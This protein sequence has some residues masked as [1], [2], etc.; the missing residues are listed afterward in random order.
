MVALTNLI[1]DGCGGFDIAACEALGVIAV[2]TCDH[3][4]NIFRSMPRR[5][6]KSYVL[7]RIHTV[8]SDFN[9][10]HTEDLCKSGSLAFTDSTPSFLLVTSDYKHS[11]HVVN[12]ETW[13]VQGFV[14]QNSPKIS[15]RRVA[16]KGSWLAFTSI[17]C[18]YY[19]EGNHCV[20]LYTGHGSDW[21]SVARVCNFPI[22]SIRDLFFKSEELFVMSERQL[23]R[24]DCDADYRGVYEWTMVFDAS[25]SG[26]KVA[27]GCYWGQ[28]FALVSRCTGA[29]V[30]YNQDKDTMVR[31]DYEEPNMSLGVAVVPRVGLGLIHAYGTSQSPLTLFVTK[32]VVAMAN[33]SS[34][35]VAWMCAVYRS[36]STGERSVHVR[37]SDF[38]KVRPCLM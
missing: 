17:F 20:H 8:D 29:L 4:I 24:M 3:T 11:L 21:K 15:P 13:T 32:D 6:Q 33:M 36:E 14:V 10:G 27:C 9:F 2:S 1:V 26:F 22:D 19:A 28:E 23:Y 16:T 18:P 34:V 31:L 5:V 12:T 38:K 35:K 30:L 7:D 25:S 37:S